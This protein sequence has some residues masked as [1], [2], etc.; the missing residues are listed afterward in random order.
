MAF[1]DSIEVLTKEEQFSGKIRSFNNEYL[2]VF[3]IYRIIS[4]SLRH[5]KVVDYLEI[6]NMIEKVEAKNGYAAVLTSGEEG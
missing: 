2:A 5:R 1:Q 4:V 3:G 6:T